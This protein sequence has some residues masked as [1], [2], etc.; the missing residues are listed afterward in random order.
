MAELLAHVRTGLPHLR[1]AVLFEDWSAF[2]GSGS[3]SQ[4]LPVVSPDDPAQVQYTS[5]TTGTPKGAVLHHRGITNNARLSYA[6]T[7]AMRPGEPFVNPM[8]LFHTAGCVLATLAPIT[9]LGTQVLLP[10]FDPAL[11]LH[12]MESE[13]SAVFGGVPTMILAMLGHPDFAAT[14]LSSVRYALSGGA[15]VPPELIRRVEAALGVPMTT[16]YAQTEASPGITMT[17]LEDSPDDRATTVGRPLPGCEVD[18]VDPATGASCPP[19]RIGEVRTRGYHV[20]TG[21]LGLPEQTAQAIDADG[22][23]HTGDL[24]SRDER[25]Y[26]R[27]E[28]RIKDMII[29]GGENIYPREIE[30]ALLTHPAIDAAAVVG[31]PDPEWGEQ[32]AAFVR[33]VPGVA[34]FPARRR[35]RPSSSTTSAAS[36]RRTRH[37]GCGGSSRSSR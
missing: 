25:G 10:W 27:I 18:I 24:G 30:H 20:M 4:P 36:W 7:L 17:S 8:P 3:P 21:Y 34:S 6:E 14:D 23:L 31:V 2:L 5:G 19:G 12:V 29:R 1:E 16:A 35:T 11:Q 33:L 28:G 26:L 37:P 9:T 13:R 32:V 15:L 22:W